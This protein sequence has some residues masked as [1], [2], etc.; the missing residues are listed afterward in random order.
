MEQEG[1][2]QRNE[3]ASQIA[4][5]KKLAQHFPNFRPTKSAPS[6]F[7]LNAC[8]LSM[9][10]SS[11]REPETGAYQKAHCITLIFTPIFILG[12]YVVVDSPDR[13]WYFLGKTKLTYFLRFGTL[14]SSS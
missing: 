5:Q 11:N 8:G 2:N 6:L 1:T 7:L 13:G 12:S 4:I 3:E 14:F 10:G 9:A